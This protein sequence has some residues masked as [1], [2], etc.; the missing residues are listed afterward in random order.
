M[1]GIELGWSP[2]FEQAFLGLEDPAL[3]PARVVCAEREHYR[4]IARDGATYEGEPTG[5]LRH[6]AG[7]GELPVVGDWV[8][9]RLLAGE[10]RAAIETCLPRMSVLRRKRP[11]RASEAQL[12]AANVDLV[13]VVTALDHDFNVRRVERALALVWESGAQPVLLLSKLDLCDD[14]EPFLQA[15]RAVALGVD[16][17]A[18]S[19]QAGSGLDAAFGALRPGL[20]AVLIGSSGVGKSTLVNHLLGSEQQRTAYVRASDERG[21]HTTTRRELFP[22]A[23][24]AL[25]IDTPG[26][27]ELG[28][29]DAEDG[30]QATFD[31]V[32]RLAAQC[33]FGDCSHQGEPGCA[34]HAAVTSGELAAERVSSYHKLRRELAHEARRQDARAALE[35]RHENRKLARARTR[36]WR[37]NPK[38]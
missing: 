20:T 2:A 34:L 38:R 11:D 36:A 3:Q 19:A 28:L 6:R 30:L 31:D 27:R 37:Q 21:R 18:L 5:K 23:S 4:V 17:H 13:Y 7:L 14:P 15:M 9:A 33:R 1:N 25:L 24:G 29:F 8:A 22:L 32:E 12:I 16:V 35:Y 10:G 26:M